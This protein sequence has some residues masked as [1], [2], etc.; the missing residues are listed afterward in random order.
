MFID[1]N[2]SVSNEVYQLALQVSNLFNCWKRESA[3]STIKKITKIK[4]KL[5]LKKD[6]LTISPWE[7]SFLVMFIFWIEAI[8]KSLTA[9]DL[10]QVLLSKNP[11]WLC[12]RF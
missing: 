8:Q 2:I 7:Q 4:L 10:L 5:D 3:P 1:I 11:C 12:F 6:N 9:F